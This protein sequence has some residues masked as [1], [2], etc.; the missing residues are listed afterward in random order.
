MKYRNCDKN[1]F[2]NDLN[3]IN[4]RNG[5]EKLNKCYHLLTK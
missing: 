5:K 1:N 4:V 3:N 2:V